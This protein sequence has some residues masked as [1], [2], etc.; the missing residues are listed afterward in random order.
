MLFIDKKKI[1]Y[2]YVILNIVFVAVI[3]SIRVQHSIT[4]FSILKDRLWMSNILQIKYIINYIQIAGGMT[5]ALLFKSN[6]LDPF[7]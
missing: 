7:Y 6:L 3:C 5:I 1:K 2:K 4:M